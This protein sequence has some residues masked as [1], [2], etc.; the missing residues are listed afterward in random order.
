[1]NR[2]SQR[3]PIPRRVA[4]Q[5]PTG[6]FSNIPQMRYSLLVSSYE[7]V[8]QIS[9]GNEWNNGVAFKKVQFSYS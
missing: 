1:M 5:R 3:T 2:K 6:N 4:V 7:R 9:M 8:F